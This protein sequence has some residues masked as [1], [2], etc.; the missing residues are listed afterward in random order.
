MCSSYPF[1]LP[2]D[3]EAD[4][5]AGARAAN[6]SPLVGAT[7]EGTGDPFQYSCL[8]NPK[9]RRAQGATVRRVAKSDLT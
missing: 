7:A 8:G 3:W 2:T 1:L 5:M 4:I 9:D 6:L